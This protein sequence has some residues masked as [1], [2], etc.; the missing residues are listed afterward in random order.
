MSKK[1]KSTKG[2]V[3]STDPAFEYK[4]DEE[5]SHDTLP[6]PQQNLRVQ[7]DKKQRGGKAVSLITGFVGSLSDLESLGKKMKQKCGVG[8]T[9]KDGEIIIQGDFVEKILTI[10]QNSGYKVKKIGGSKVY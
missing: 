4:F 8:G 6:P 2:V 9:V 1:N 10:L 7:L 5:Q 3:Y